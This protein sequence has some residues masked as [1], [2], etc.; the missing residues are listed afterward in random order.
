MI[1]AVLTRGTTREYTS[2]LILEENKKTR[3]PKNEEGGD[4]ERETR[5]EESR[6]AGFAWT[7]VAGQEMLLNTIR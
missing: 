6:S 5:E 2:M 3:G 1:A 4:G 7:T